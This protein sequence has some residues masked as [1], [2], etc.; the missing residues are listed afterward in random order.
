MIMS[1]KLVFT[2]VAAFYH[3]SMFRYYYFRY[4][5]LFMSDYLLL[6]VDD[7]GWLKW[8]AGYFGF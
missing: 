7:V 6:V 5:Y 4:Y 8:I 1:P 2:H 3:P